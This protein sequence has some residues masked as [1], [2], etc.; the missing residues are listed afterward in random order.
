MYKRISMNTLDG[1]REIYS[2]RVDF[3]AE[4]ANGFEK[5]HGAQSLSAACEGISNRVAQLCGIS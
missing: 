1:K 2:R 3:A 4:H 5:K